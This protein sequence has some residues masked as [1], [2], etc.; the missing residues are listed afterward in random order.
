MNRSTKTLFVLLVIIVYILILGIM[1]KFIEKSR[2]QQKS[3]NQHI[4]KI[5]KDREELQR[6][7]LALTSGVFIEVD[8][9]F[10]LWPIVPEDFKRNT[11]WVGPRTLP[12]YGGQYRHHRGLD[13]KGVE[14]ARIQCSADG[15]ISDVYP[16][17][18]QSPK[19]P[20]GGEWRGHETKGGYVEVTHADGFVTRNSHLSEVFP[21]W[22][23]IGTPIKAGDIIGRQ[24]STG[25]SLAPHLH[26]EVLEDEQHVNPL[27]YL[28]EIM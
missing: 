15:Y 27:K 3:A 20:Q 11:S 17:P 26:F 23:V 5:E 22:F 2:T 19:P 12:A 6:E 21:K 8:E 28:I 16:A 13:M 1:L 25:L 18:G 4:E 9:A 14:M 24:G 7:I 10:L